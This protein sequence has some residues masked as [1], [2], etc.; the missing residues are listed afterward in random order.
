VGVSTAEDRLTEYAL[1]ASKGDGDA[2]LALIRASRPEVWRF[3]AGL[4]RS[5][6][7]DDLTQETFLRVVRALPGYAGRASAR[8]WLLAIARRVCADHL[9]TVI[10]QRRLGDK[11]SHL[12]QEYVRVDA[13][14]TSELLSVLPDERRVAFVLTQVV[15][16]SYAEAAEIERVPVGTIRSRV[17][18]A[19]ADLVAA[20]RAAQAS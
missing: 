15:G 9:R 10:R 12:P 20:V 4:T 14:A 8:T 3:V 1:A 11:L 18:R 5:A 7:A 2:T 19:R 16:L 17:A 6:D 13:D